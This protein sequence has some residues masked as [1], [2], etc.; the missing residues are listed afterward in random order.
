MNSMPNDEEKV[1][2]NGFEVQTRFFD[3]Q[4]LIGI[5]TSEYDKVL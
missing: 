4:V 3:Y 2:I 5:N 1:I